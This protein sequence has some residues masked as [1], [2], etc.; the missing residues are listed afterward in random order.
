MRPTEVLAR[1]LRISYLYNALL[2]ENC[3]ELAHLD[4]EVIQMMCLVLL[5][6]K[7]RGIRLNQ[8]PRLME[9]LQVVQIGNKLNMEAR[10]FV[11]KL[12]QMAGDRSS[13]S[14]ENTKKIREHARRCFRILQSSNWR[15]R[16]KDMM[17]NSSAAAKIRRAVVEQWNSRKPEEGTMD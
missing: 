9:L 2:I 11:Q 1:Y 10:S 14:D 5:K 12:E 4:I 15:T 3:T 17:N 6:S 7:D 16:L 13:T 8:T